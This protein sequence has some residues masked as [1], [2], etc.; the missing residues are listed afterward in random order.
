M[1]DRLVSADNVIWPDGGGWHGVGS[2][3]SSYGDYLK[4]RMEG[5]L[6]S[7]T[8]ALLCSA[9]DVALLGASGLQGG[10][11]VPAERAFPVYLRDQVAR[12]PN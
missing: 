3:W 12:K 8:P 11:G 10:D 2:G 4:R 7:V 9:R 5:D 1:D 6:Q